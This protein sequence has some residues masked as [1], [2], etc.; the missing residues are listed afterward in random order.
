MN[1]FVKSYYKIQYI[2][3]LIKILNKFCNIPEQKYFAPLGILYLFIKSLVIPFVDIASTFFDSL[4]NSF[5]TSTCFVLF[6]VTFLL[7]LF[8]LSSKFVLFTKLPI[9]LL[10]AKFAHANLAAKFSDVNL[11]NYWVIIYLVWS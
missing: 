11:L 4:F 5:C 1:K 8:S 7:K 6:E 3:W 10:L 9:S 2:Y